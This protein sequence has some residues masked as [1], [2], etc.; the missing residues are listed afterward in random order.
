MPA[1]TATT[2]GPSNIENERLRKELNELKVRTAELERLAQAKTENGELEKLSK[3]LD[4][5][6]SRVKQLSDAEDRRADAED[7][8]AHKKT[9]TAAASASVNSVLSVL[10]SGNTSNIEPSLRYAESV[11]TGNAQRDVQLAR[12][13]LANG[14]VSSARQYLLLA[15]AEAEAQR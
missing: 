6:N 2:P 1:A 12:A 14:D 11:F 13:A 15:I 9:S 4:E 3:K 10:A 8:A 7:A 5:L